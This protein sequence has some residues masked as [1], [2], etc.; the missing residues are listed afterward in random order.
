MVDNLLLSSME[1]LSEI[2]DLEARASDILD[3]GQELLD[4]SPDTRVRIEHK[5]V[6]SVTAFDIVLM[7]EF[8]SSSQYDDMRL[9]V[10]PR[11]DSEEE[12]THPSNVLYVDVG[13]LL[14]GIFN[15]TCRD[16]SAEDSVCEAVSHNDKLAE[17]I[18]LGY[19]ADLANG[20]GAN[21]PASTLQR[22]EAFFR[23]TAADGIVTK[24][25]SKYWKLPDGTYLYA[26]YHSEE[27]L[28][29]G[30]A[31][32]ESIA[33]PQLMIARRIKD[34]RYQIER[35][36]VG[37]E[38][39]LRPANPFEYHAQYASSVERNEETGKIISTSSNSTDQAV[40]LALDRQRG[41]RSLN[42]VVIDQ[43][44]RGL[45]ML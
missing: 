25:A 3:Q 8:D 15:A 32:L 35:N 43:V 44:Q 23:D 19:L 4:T 38:S 21:V 14:R 22:V 30:V 31:P 27:N 13:S 33:M 6:L 12:C 16:R 42:Q 11:D 5:R 40:F 37:I 9:F 39:F 26:S 29:E 2:Q 24:D 18:E 34:M 36:S 45:E 1:K 17:L 20:N 10:Y 41:V 28:P 7:H